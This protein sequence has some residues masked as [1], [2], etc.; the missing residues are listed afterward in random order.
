[1]NNEAKKIREET[2]GRE[3]RKN[4]KART[5]LEFELALQKQLPQDEESV[6]VP[7]RIDDSTGKA[8]SWKTIKR[9]EYVSI[10]EEKLEDVG[11][12]IKT[13]EKL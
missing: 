10:V 1:M 6:K 4:V 8:L 9:S 5:M 13:L 3:L 7:G 2:I 11:L 12:R